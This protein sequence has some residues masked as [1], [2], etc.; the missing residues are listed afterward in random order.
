MT[1]ET[2]EKQPARTNA[3]HIKIAGH[4]KMKVA[5]RYQLIAGYLKGHQGEPVKLAEIATAMNC[6][7]TVA[8]YTARSGE[9]AKLRAAEGLTLAETKGVFTV[10][11]AAPKPRARKTS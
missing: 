2:T 10:T 1:T 4:I 3:G 5:D 11:P 8:D 9:V 6:S 7:T